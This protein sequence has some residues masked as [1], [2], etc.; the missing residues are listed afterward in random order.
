MLHG[1]QSDAAK[2]VIPFKIGPDHEYAHLFHFLGE[3]VH[4]LPRGPRIDISRTLLIKHESQRICSGSNRSLR[5]FR[6]RDSANLYPGHENQLSAHGTQ[7]RFL[8]ALVLRL[9][10]LMLASSARAEHLPETSPSSRIPLSKM[11]HIRLPEAG[12]YLPLSECRF[13]QPARHFLGSVQPTEMPSAN[14]LWTSADRG[15]SRRSDCNRRPQHAATLQH[16]VH[17]TARPGCIQRLPPPAW[18]ILLATVQLRSATR[19]QQNKL[20]LPATEIHLR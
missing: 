19:H 11:C 15:C 9:G 6:I 16:R 5:V 2:D 3:L 4:N 8:A 13:R 7:C 12:R 10:Y 17:R 18:L 20:A 1:C 14:R